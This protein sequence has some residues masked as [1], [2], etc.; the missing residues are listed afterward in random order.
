MARGD[1]DRPTRRQFLARSALLSAGL[2]AGC[3]PLGSSAAQAAAG[4]AFVRTDGTRF[5]LGRQPFRVAGA[6]THYLGWASRAEVDDVLTT[7]QRMG[8]NVVR[9]IMSCVIGSLDGTTRRSVWNWGSTEDSSNMGVHGVHLLYWDTRRGTW[10]WNDSSVNGLGR[11]DYVIHR[12]GQLGLRLNISLLDYWQWAGGA[13]Q[14]VAWLVPGYNPQSDP[15]RRTLFFANPQAR[16]IYKQWV[17]HVLNR[18]N[19]ITGVRYRDDPTIF[20]WDLMNEPQIDNGARDAA[21]VPLARSWLAEMAAHVRSIDPNH[22]VTAG[23]EGFF[24]RSGVLDA[25]AELRLPGLHFGSWHLYPDYHRVS[26]AQAIDLARRHAAT[27]VAAGKPVLLQEFGYGFQHGDQP[28]VYRAWLRALTDDPNCA[29]WAFWRLVGRTQPPPTRR[30]PEAESDRLAGFP[31][32]NGER[33]DIIDD[34]R[35]APSTAYRSAAVLEAAARR[36]R[37]YP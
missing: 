19:G 10:A 33:F 16:S 3:A 25:G 29:G 8:L 21:G 11:W 4:G 23:D 20:A 6:N 28:D 14:I 17:A 31:S 15:R 27:A 35:A 9:S 26:P 30:F 7:A 2:A 22:L 18:V 32:D 37:G 24:D 12:A 1:R 13:Q 5:V 36:I 34:A